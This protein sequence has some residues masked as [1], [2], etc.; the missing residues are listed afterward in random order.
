[1]LQESSRLRQPLLLLRPKL[2]KIN[3]ICNLIPQN[4]FYR[5]NFTWNIKREILVIHNHIILSLLLAQT[6]NIGLL[7]ENTRSLPSA[8]LPY[9]WKGIKQY[10]YLSGRKF[11]LSFHNYIFSFVGKFTKNYREYHI[12][13]YIKVW[14][15]QRKLV[16][17]QHI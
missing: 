1:M 13:V 6:L 15:L 7:Q 12:L 8:T 5:V 14:R 11:C 3:E 16:I 17:L 4:I 2:Q 9:L 10:A